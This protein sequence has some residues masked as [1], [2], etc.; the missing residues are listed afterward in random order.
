MCDCMIC[1]RSKGVCP[2]IRTE[3]EEFDPRFYHT[4][5]GYNFKTTEFMA[6][7]GLV[8][9]KKA[10]WIKKRR[11][12]NVKFLNDEL[13][14]YSDTLQLPRYSNEISNLA[15]PI[16]IKK[17]ETVARS[18]LMYELERL[19][20]ETRPLFGCIPTQQPAYE[21]LKQKYGGKL[22]NAE[23]IGKNAF[24]IGCHQYLTEEDLSYVANAFEKIL[25]SA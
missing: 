17:T 20:I 2:Y 9:L 7:L 14:K 10:D 15:Y 6:A 5:I 1:T 13:S 4:H 21:H 8:Q 19:G 25:S 16:V 12:E 22:P 3:D 11:Q 18:K 23:C 24:Y